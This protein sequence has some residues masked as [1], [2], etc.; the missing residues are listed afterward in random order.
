MVQGKGWGHS[1]HLLL[2]GEL[3]IK[4]AA[5]SRNI[6]RASQTEKKDGRAG[7]GPA[8]WSLYSILSHSHPTSHLPP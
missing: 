2:S 3:S 8:G 5:F 1:S 6:S 4:S 7:E